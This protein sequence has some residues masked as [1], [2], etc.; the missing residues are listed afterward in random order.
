MSA[1]DKATAMRADLGAGEDSMGQ[2]VAL[3][4]TTDRNML[5]RIQRF[6]FRDTPRR[7][8]LSRNLFQALKSA[9]GR[10]MMRGVRHSTLK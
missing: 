10:Q 4:S 9:V 8:R 5:S 1:G 2:F 7:S 3:A 6:L